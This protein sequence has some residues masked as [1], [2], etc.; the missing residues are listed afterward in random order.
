M[1]SQHL[2]KLAHNAGSFGRTLLMSLFLVACG[3]GVESGG[4]G[5]N[6]TASY[7]SGPITGF[8]SVIVGGV[9][10]DDATA[11]VADA[12]GDARSRD[13]LKLGMTITV[14]GTPIVGDGSSAATSIVVGSAIVGP[15]SA[16]NSGAATMT[17]LGQP[18]DVLTTTVF[19]ESLAGGLAALSVGDV[20]EVY[21]LLDTATQRYRATRI[22][23][24]RVALVYQLRGVVTN[25]NTENSTFK[26]GN[27]GISYDALSDSDVPVGLANGSIVRV[28]L[29][30]VPVAGLREA[31]R[32]RL[33]VTAPRDLEE[34]RIEGLISAFESS[35]VFSVDGVQVDAARASFPDGTAGLAVGARVALRGAVNNGV[36]SAT[37]V[38]IKSESQVEDDG[39]ELRGLIANIDT[40]ARLFTLRGVSV[41]YSGPVEYRD[42]TQADLVI[43][44][45]EVEVE[46][47][48]SSDGTRLVATRIEFRR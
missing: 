31:L 24:K 46:G 22:E 7:V 29:R 16:I 34:V 45:V 43:P 14:R 10:F 40:M 30:I 44:N 4:T 5:G 18:V 38:Q 35:A 2:H 8:G 25:L 47:R 19:D 26:V 13:D 27:Q 1:I 28:V 42:G 37:Q 39:F 6:A 20:V 21:A 9:R 12:E 33:G 17:V 15:V 23:R 11:T 32:L 41:D 3:G 48:L 36:L